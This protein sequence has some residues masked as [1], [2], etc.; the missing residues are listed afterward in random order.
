MRTLPFIRFAWLLPMLLSVQACDLLTVEPDCPQ[1][2]KAITE[3]QNEFAFRMLREVSQDAQP[4]DN[5]FISPLSIQMALG[6]TAN[7]AVGETREEMLRALGTDAFRIEELNEANRSALCRLASLDPR[8]KAALANSVWIREGFPVHQAFIDLVETE[9]SAEVRTENFGDPGAVDLINQWA[10]DHTE[11]KID[12]ILESISP[13]YVMFLINAIYFEAPWRRA[14]DP[15][16][17]QESLFTRP[18]GSQVNCQMMNG[19]KGYL[20][21]QDA[22]VTIADVPY[23]K[24]SAFSMTLIAPEY[25]KSADSLLAQFDE[26]RWDAWT[27]LLDT[28]SLELFMPKLELDAEYDLIPALWRM[29]MQRAFQDNA[30]FSSLTD[31]S[32]MIDLV[33]HNSYLKADEAG[34]TAAAVTTVGIVETSLPPA[35]RFDRPFLLAIRERATN[36]I[37]FL[38]VIRDPS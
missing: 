33:K 5:L 23:G 14:F 21:Y 2:K 12:E 27:S 25:G 38:G 32:V 35:L 7:G 13:D 17:T 1:A 30:E 26:Q 9:Y 28:T 24:E 22:E 16:L 3:A 19:K 37:L 11:G 20:G 31:Q 34:T 15:D 36:Q 6:M 8:V 10:S 29:G 18:D 4:G